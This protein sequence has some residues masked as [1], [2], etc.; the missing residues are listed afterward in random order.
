[1]LTHI[2]QFLFNQRRNNCFMFC[3]FLLK[4][5]SK[6]SWGK[7]A[8]VILNGATL[9]TSSQMKIKERRTQKADNLFEARDLLSLC[10]SPHSLPPPPRP[11]H[12]PCCSSSS[13]SYLVINGV[14]FAP[15]KKKKGPHFTVHYFKAPAETKPLCLLRWKWAVKYSSYK[16]SDRTTAP[17]RGRREL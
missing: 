3:G 8:E 16:G 7:V 15:N 14:N 6:S 9:L 5:T 12:P 11:L 17:P 10:S 13:S 4:A 2:D 1:M